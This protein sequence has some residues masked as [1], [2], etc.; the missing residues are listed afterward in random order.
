MLMT[1]IL[2]T[3]THSSRIRLLLD[4]LNMDFALKDLGSLSFF[5]GIQA[6]RDAHGL[7][8]RQSKYI[9]DLLH[10]AHMIGAKPYGSPCVSGS[11]LSSHE[12]DSIARLRVLP[13]GWGSSILHLGPSRNCLFN[14]PTLPIYAQTTLYSLDCLE[15][16]STLS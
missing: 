4:H 6:T 13:T 15:T 1:Y 3:G 5:L 12:G 16:C 2:I 10:K 11:K 8:L 14:Q 9:L 7:H